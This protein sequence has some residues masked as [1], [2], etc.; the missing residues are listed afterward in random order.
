MG[1]V[2]V[3]GKKPFL[4]SLGFATYVSGQLDVNVVTPDLCWFRKRESVVTGPIE[5]MGEPG[6]P[7]TK[8]S[9]HVE[10]PSPPIFTIGI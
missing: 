9:I 7:A 10:K 6:P 4:A 2:K 8:F 5:K 3:N 1:L